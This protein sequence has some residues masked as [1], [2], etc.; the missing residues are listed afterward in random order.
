MF[1]DLLLD[2][3]RLTDDRFPNGDTLPVVVDDRLPIPPG[4][5][6]GVRCWVLVVF[7][8]S[9]VLVLNAVP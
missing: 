1:P 2:V 9:A 7:V 5:V 6:D 4:A 8:R 3:G